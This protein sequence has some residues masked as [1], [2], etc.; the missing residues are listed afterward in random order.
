MGPLHA[1]RRRLSCEHG[2]TLAEILVAVLIISIGLIGVLTTFDASERSS[3]AAQRHEQAL[4]V[5][6]RELERMKSISYSTL[7]LSS[8]PAPGG[9]GNPAGDPRPNNPRNPN[10]YVTTGS[11]FSIKA[12]YADKNSTTLRSETLVGA[13]SVIQGP[14]SFDAGAGTG[15][16]YRYITYRTESCSGCSGTTD[17]KRITVAVVMDDDK[18]SA[19]TRP[20]YLST[21]VTD[22]NAS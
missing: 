15:K 21:V 7:G 19:P 6:Q 4:A 2:F 8:I 16:I 17:S 14:E 1:L 10:F 13:G 3:Q 18:R 12:D 22:P 5:G 9:D 20:I 11:L